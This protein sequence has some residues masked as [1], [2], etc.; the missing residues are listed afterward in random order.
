MDIYLEEGKI[1]R[2]I[3]LKNP[4]GALDPPLQKAPS[5]RKLDNFAWLK[6]IRPKDRWDIFRKVSEKNIGIKENI[7]TEDPNTRLR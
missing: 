5:S 3:F 4:D 6:N 7:E 2:I 1:E